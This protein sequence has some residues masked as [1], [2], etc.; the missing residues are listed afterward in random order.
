MKRSG[1]GEDMKISISRKRFM[2]ATGVERKLMILSYLSERPCSTSYAVSTSLE[3]SERGAL[4]HLRSMVK[5]EILD[6]IEIEGKHR[7]FIQ[8]QIKKEDCRIFSILSE[9]RYREVFV[10]L[11]GKSGA[12]H[13]E[14]SDTF[15]ASRQSMWKIVKKLMSVG[16]VK[17]IR[18]GR[19]IRYFPS[20]KVGDMASV[21]SERT[22]A[23]ATIIESSIKKTG[24]EYM[25]IVH[26]NGIL[27]LRIGEKEVSFS[28][29]PFR[30]ILEG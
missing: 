18:E 9:K 20:K 12:T 23:V 3:I 2:E 19:H 11:L 5:K 22:E 17:E 16:L 25:V 14:L 6:E 15:G 24:L 8:G 30:S 27:H 1:I 13:S 28:T 26:R 21:Y 29:D 4:W 10:F 7:F